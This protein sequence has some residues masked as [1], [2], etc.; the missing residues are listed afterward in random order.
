MQKTTT[1]SHAS[2]RLRTSA[3]RNERPAQRTLRSM[4]PDAQF[5]RI[6]ETMAMFGATRTGLC[7]VAADDPDLFR[8]ASRCI[9]VDLAVRPRLLEQLPIIRISGAGRGPVA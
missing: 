8:M 6:P 5:R 1:L 2:L 4:L 3:G 9:L 7:W